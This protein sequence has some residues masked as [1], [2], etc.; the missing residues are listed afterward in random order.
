MTTIPV[1]AM[2]N[3]DKEYTVETC[4]WERNRGSIDARRETCGL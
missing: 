1:L 3:F 2:P 4:I